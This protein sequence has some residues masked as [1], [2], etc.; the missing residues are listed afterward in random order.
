MIMD[1]AEADVLACMNFPKEHRAK[2][3]STNP[4]ERVNG[5]I[6]RRTDVVGIF[7]NDEAIIRLIGMIRRKWSM[8]P[9]FCRRWLM[10]L[11]HWLMI[12]W[13]ISLGRWLAIMSDSPNLR[14]SFAMRSAAS[15]A[16][17]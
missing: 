10:K 14:P 4:L 6:K 17:R 13:L 5:E 8:S 2:L 1:E 16:R 11:A 15:R 9:G 12:V 3:H 7:P